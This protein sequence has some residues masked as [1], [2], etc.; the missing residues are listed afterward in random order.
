MR[1]LAIIFLNNPVLELLHQINFISILFL[2]IISL[3]IPKIKIIC[4][5]QYPLNKCF[6]FFTHISGAL[7]YK[8]I[9]NCDWSKDDVISEGW[10]GL[11]KT[12]S[13]ICTRKSPPSPNFSMEFEKNWEKFTP[14]FSWEWSYFKSTAQEL[15]KL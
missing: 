2:S 15:C 13:P 4:F 11:H 12:I 7:I 6:A 9:L 5:P 1:K 8:E 10:Q 3:N 14:N